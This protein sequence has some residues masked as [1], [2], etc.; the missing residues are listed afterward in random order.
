VQNVLSWAQ[1]LLPSGP[2]LIYSTADAE[3]VKTTQTDL[4]SDATGTRVEQA[5][6]EIAKGLIKLGVQQLVVAGGETSGACVMA[7]GMEQMQIGPQIDTGVP[8]C[9]GLRCQHSHRAQIG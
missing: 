3:S 8:W 9:Y 5:L 2:V 4:G 1:A 7:L 6:S